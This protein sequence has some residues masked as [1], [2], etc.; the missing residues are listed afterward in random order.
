MKKH[1]KLI[2]ILA[3]AVI[4]LSGFFGAFYFIN[5]STLR[6]HTDR[7]MQTFGGF[8][9]SAAWWSQDVGGWDN[10][11]EIINY[12]YSPDHLNLDIYRFNVGA[13]S[14]HERFPDWNSNYI[15]DPLRRTDSFFTGTDT[16]G[17]HDY[18]DL[19]N[20]DF[21]RDR[22]AV[23]A[24][25][26][27]VRAGARE[28]VFFANSPHWTLTK[29]NLAF[30]SREHE[31]NIASEN[32]RKFAQYM[33]TI[34]E[35][36]ITRSD[37]GLKIPVTAISPINEP[38]WGWGR[39]PS[40][41][42]G[43]EGMHLSPESVGNILKV[44]VEVRA[45][46]G[47]THI[48]ILAPES[49]EIDRH[50]KAYLHEIYNVHGLQDEIPVFAQHSYWVDGDTAAKRRFGRYMQKNYPG[51]R[52]AQTEWC[53]M[54]NGRD[55]GMRSAL[56]M[57]RVISDD[58]NYLFAI[59]WDFWIAVSPYIYNDS[60]MYIY[61]NRSFSFPKRYYIM[62]QYSRFILSD[63]IIIE[64]GF[65]FSNRSRN[66]KAVTAK[67]A[68]GT[69]MVVITNSGRRDVNIRLRGVSGEYERYVTD[70]IRNTESMGSGSGRVT[71]GGQSVVTLVFRG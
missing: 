54:E 52:L 64:S 6:I 60:L 1:E 23:D 27:A 59:S 28:V 50:S 32:Y 14:H 7:D 16:N 65:N 17:N 4:A 40:G 70:E 49:G 36:F 58:I 42:V 24:M 67:R 19:A 38:Q 41:W 8:G 46:M 18:T 33:F 57:S 34:A 71:V 56:R 62:K 44:F 35:Y 12:L 30:G 5:G 68:D 43:Q 11:E 69:V 20:Y 10:A 22:N 48:G 25:E 29:N 61:N 55:Y 15:W 2:I 26:M 9:A 53:H 37:G 3:A 47:L 39:Q 63:D 31:E 51:V 13:G 66:L 21:G 45:E